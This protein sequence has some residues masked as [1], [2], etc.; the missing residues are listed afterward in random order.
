MGK[1]KFT[2][3]LAKP[4]DPQKRT[5]GLINSAMG[6]KP[7]DYDCYDILKLLCKRYGIKPEPSQY[8]DLA[9]ALAFDVVPALQK[10][11][12][13][14]AKQKWTD[15]NKACLVVEIERLMFTGDS[16]NKD[17]S[18]A[19]KTLAKKEP[20]KSFVNGKDRP[21]TLRQQ[22][23]KFKKNKSVKNN[24]SVKNMHLLVMYYQLENRLDKW[25]DI[26]AALCK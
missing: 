5:R 12:K 15:R 23:Y 4:I 9:L 11:T 6:K 2:G 3:P 21:G 10:K 19:V 22:Y 13:V 26:L 8:S 24:E 18:W 25:E 20:W 17:I 14:G 1:K 16:C 7:G